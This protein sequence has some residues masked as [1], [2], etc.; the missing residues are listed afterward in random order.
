MNDDTHKIFQR[1]DNCII[2]TVPADIDDEQLKLITSTS[3]DFIKSEAF[4]GMVIDFSQLRALDKNTMDSLFN[5]AK[6]IRTMGVPVR[7]SCISAGLASSLAILDFDPGR[8]SV[9][10]SLDHALNKLK[11]AR[12]AHSN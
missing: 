4:D 3:C 1:L 8:I 7:A 6:A 5:L 12:M 2:L 10:G 11:S 9:S